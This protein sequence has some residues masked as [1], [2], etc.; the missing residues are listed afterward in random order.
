MLTTNQP[1]ALLPS[2]TLTDIISLRDVEWEAREQAFHDQALEEVNALVRKYNGLAPYAVRRAYYLRRTE[3]DRTYR[4]SA[5]AIL[6][7]LAERVGAQGMRMGAGIGE[8]DSEGEGRTTEGTAGGTATS[9]SLRD[10]LRDWWA[11]LRGR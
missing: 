5:E 8:D 11:A 7:G 9:L 10:M 3:L 2:L 6:Q 1:A 4:D